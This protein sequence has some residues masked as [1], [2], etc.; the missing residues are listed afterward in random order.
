MNAEVVAQL[1]NIAVQIDTRAVL[2]EVDL[3]VRAGE[4]WVLMGPN[5]GGKST[6]LSVL[7]GRRHPSS[8]TVTIDGFRLGHDDLRPLR[9]RIGVASALLVDQ[10]R[11]SITAA[12]A[13]VT[14]RKGAF[15]TWWDSYTEADWHAA[16]ARLSDVGLAGRG[17]QEFGTLSSGERQRCLLARA[18]VND[19]ALLILD[20][21][22]AGLDFGG[23]EQLLA[24]IEHLAAQRG[25][26]PTVMA[27]HHVEDIHRRA[28]HLLALADGRVIAAGPLGTTLTE[29]VLSELFGLDVNLTRDQGRWAA[30]ARR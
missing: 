21:P 16:D 18:L 22:T 11:P 20:E 8:G 14:G 27:T 17:G 10:L 29:P 1:R 28:T 12:E 24:T 5:G 13:V 15:E 9:R 2:S 23:R 30:V 4:H 3:T 7:A 6:L 25:G 19:P 26:P